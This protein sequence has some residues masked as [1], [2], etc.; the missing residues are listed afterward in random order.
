MVHEATKMIY[1]AAKFDDGKWRQRLIRYFKG[2]IKADMVWKKAEFKMAFE[3]IGCSMENY[4]KWS[5]VLNRD[6]Y[7]IIIMMIIII[8]IIIIR[9]R[10]RRR[11]RRVKTCKAQIQS[12][13][14]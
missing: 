4:V 1:E 2:D 10:R 9:R 8:I 3:A 14:H 6:R 5:M 11:R 13:F 12:K 7:I